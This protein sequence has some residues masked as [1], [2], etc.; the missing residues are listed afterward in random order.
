MVVSMVIY[1]RGKLKRLAAQFTPY[2]W[3]DFDWKPTSSLKR[4]MAML[5]VIAI[6][7][8]IYL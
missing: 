7:S 3:T 6:V 1:Y 8:F 5:A 4:W 2:S